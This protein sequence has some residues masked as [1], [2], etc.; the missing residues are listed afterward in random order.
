[1]IKEVNFKRDLWAVDSEVF[2]A[3]LLPE[4]QS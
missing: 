2:I 3:R 4:E 1:M